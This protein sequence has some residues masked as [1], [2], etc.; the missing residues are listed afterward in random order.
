MTSDSVRLLR[1][2]WSLIPL[3][4][5]FKNYLLLLCWAYVGCYYSKVSLTRIFLVES[6]VQ[7]NDGLNISS[8]KKWREILCEFKYIFFQLCS[9]MQFFSISIFYF[10]RPHHFFLSLSNVDRGQCT[11]KSFNQN[12]LFVV[13]LTLLN[14]D[15]YE[16][17]KRKNNIF[18]KV[19]WLVQPLYFRMKFEIFV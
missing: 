9:I 19:Y 5:H 4:F 14:S 1:N 18:K 15:T 16:L 12:S 7:R 13:C 8:E 6:L 11:W 3:P 10:F 2:T 17:K